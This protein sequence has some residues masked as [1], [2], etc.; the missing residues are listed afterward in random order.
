MKKELMC[1]VS[2]ALSKPEALSFAKTLWDGEQFY[3]VKV[4][5]N[6]KARHIARRERWVVARKPRKGEVVEPGYALFAKN[7]EKVS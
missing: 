5:E 3:V 4:S 7:K 6:P 1:Q 2:I